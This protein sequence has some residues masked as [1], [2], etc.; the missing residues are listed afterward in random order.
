MK[1]VFLL[2]LICIAFS[3]SNTKEDAPRKIKEIV[4]GDS[5]DQK[6]YIETG[7]EYT[8]RVPGTCD[9]IYEATED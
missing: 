7:E 4:C 8:M 9:T 5:V 3:C 6:V 2:S 1:N